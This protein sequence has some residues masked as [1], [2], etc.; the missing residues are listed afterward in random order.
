VFA[1]L[2]AFII[3]GTVVT[4]PMIAGGALILTASGLAAL[5]GKKRP[6]PVPKQA[7]RA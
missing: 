3:N 4:A 2:S 7:L 6:A 1:A 5:A